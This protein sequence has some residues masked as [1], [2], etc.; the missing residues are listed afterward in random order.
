MYNRILVPVDGSAASNHGLLEA[1]KLVK[2]MSAKL[3]LV[4]VVDL[5]IMDGIANR[6]LY[7]QAMIGDLRSV[8]RKVLADSESLVRQHA[9]EPSSALLEALAQRVADLVVSEAKTWGADLIV[10]GTH[11]RRGIRRLVM[12]S[13]AERV[14]RTSPVPVLLVRGQA[15]DERDIALPADAQTKNPSA[16]FDAPEQLLNDAALTIDQKIRLLR[17]W[18][19]DASEMGVALEEG[20][21]GG[22]EGLLRRILLAL[23]ALGET[24]DVEHV[25]P[26]KQ[27]GLQ[28]RREGLA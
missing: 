23:A 15:E 19:Y 24:L 8:G 21:R 22:D 20:M 10:M 6:R 16:S 7:Y 4:H 5:F 25:G 14:L 3:R 2:S 17:S 27:H 18:A 26:S 12:G 9:V 1:I 28:A 11:G 13:D